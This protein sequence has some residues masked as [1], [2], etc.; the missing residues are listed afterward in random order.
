MGCRRF[1]STSSK[2]RR[3]AV[4]CSKT[5]VRLK[6]MRSGDNRQQSHIRAERGNKATF[7]RWSSLFILSF[8]PSFLPIHL[9]ILYIVHCHVE[10][11][12]PVNSRHICPR[13]CGYP[14]RGCNV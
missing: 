12:C 4:L 11:I 8:F 6:N 9:H 2:G 7:L 3:A 14:T 10:S 1:T 13:Y 5:M